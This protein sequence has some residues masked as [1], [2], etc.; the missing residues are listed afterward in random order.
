MS[1]SPSKLTMTND[2]RFPRVG[3]GWQVA[4]GLIAAI[5]M[6][7]LIAVK[8]PL[9]EAGRQHHLAVGVGVVG[10][11]LRGVAC[12]LTRETDATRSGP[13]LYSLSFP[14][15]ATARN[16]FPP[17]K[18]CAR[19][20]GEVRCAWFRYN[21]AVSASRGPAQTR[22]PQAIARR[23]VDSKKYDPDGS[24]SDSGT[25]HARTS[26]DFEAAPKILSSDFDGGRRI[27]ACT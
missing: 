7:W 14:L 10:V 17:H 20:V 9:L 15:T 6:A 2:R 24:S 1:L 11:S 21:I 3:L 27:F 23:A 16:A 26:T 18:H 8:F 25:L 4:I 5:S 13:S 22:F 19:E 12:S